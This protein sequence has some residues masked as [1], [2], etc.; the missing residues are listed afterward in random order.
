MSGRESWAARPPDTPNPTRSELPQLRVRPGA[1]GPDDPRIDAQELLTVVAAILL[2][3]CVNLGTLQPVRASARRQEVAVRL[4]LGA[5]RWRVVRQLLTETLL[6]GTFRGIGG[7]ILAWWGKDF[8][9]WL[10]TRETPFVDA[11]IDP[12]VLAFTAVLSAITAVLLISDR[13]CARR[14]QTLDRR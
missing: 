7:T 8:M 14:A 12:R 3:V 9:L 10:P 5:S 13:R 1:Q 4:T 11:R 6:L 2:I